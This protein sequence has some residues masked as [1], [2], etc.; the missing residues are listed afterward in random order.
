MILTDFVA[1]DE[2][3]RQRHAAHWVPHVS[4][5]NFATDFSFDLFLRRQR[6]K[7]Q[8]ILGLI[9]HERSYLLN[10]ELNDSFDK[11][12]DVIL[13]QVINVVVPVTNSTSLLPWGELAR[14]DSPKISKEHIET[15]TMCKV[16][17]RLVSSMHNPSLRWV[18]HSM[19]KKND[20]ESTLLRDSVKLNNV[21]ILCLT[22]MPLVLIAS[23]MD[24]ISYWS[25]VNVVS[26]EVKRPVKTTGH[27]MECLS[28]HIND[29]VSNW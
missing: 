2:V 26:H 14:L 18:E 10:F 21:A 24:Q 19:H 25:L 27:T 20:I 15:R 13:S 5:S 6:I 8:V 12:S 17:R 23:I 9:H 7:Q 11:S 3:H 29:T 22:L 28:S 1:V 16:S 4:N